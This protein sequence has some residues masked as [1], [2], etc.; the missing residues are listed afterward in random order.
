MN[1]AVSTTMPVASTITNTSV[2][3]RNTR[4][5]PG[6]PRLHATRERKDRPRVEAARSCMTTLTGIGMRP[7]TVIARPAVMSD[8]RSPRRVWRPVV[9]GRV[10]P[11]TTP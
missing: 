2:K 10:I 8:P 4:G 1:P 3:R 7:T 6:R 9:A 11:I 5:R